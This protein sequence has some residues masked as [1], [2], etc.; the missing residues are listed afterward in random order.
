MLELDIL[1]SSLLQYRDAIC[2][3]DFEALSALLEEG[4]CRKEEVDG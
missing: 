1:I 4:K 3:E 2:D